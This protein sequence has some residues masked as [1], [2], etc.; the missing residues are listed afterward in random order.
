MMKLEDF[1][2]NRNDCLEEIQENTVK[3]EEHLKRKHINPLNK[4]RKT[5]TNM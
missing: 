3:Q 5:Q 4:Y 1:R 2:K